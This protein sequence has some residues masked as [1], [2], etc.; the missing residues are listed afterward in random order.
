MAIEESLV[1]ITLE[2]AADLS[3]NQFNVVT[4]DAAGQVNVPA[5]NT[6]PIIGV[7]QDKPAAVGRAGNVSI[8]GKTKVL[9]GGAI[10]AGDQLESDGAGGVV[11]VTGTVGVQIIGYALTDA[12]AA[13]IFTML[14]DHLG[15]Q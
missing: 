12:A 4:V 6:D 13:D 11:T 8:G 1:P 10:N 5:A 9:S 2:A 15:V 7:L 3:G 14:F